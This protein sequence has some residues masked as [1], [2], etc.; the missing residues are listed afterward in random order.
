[1]FFNRYPLI[2][3]RLRGF[4]LIELIVVIAIIAVLAAIIAPNAFKAIEKS[5]CARAIEESKTIKTG[6][7]AYYSDTGLW[8]PAYRLTSTVNPFVTNPP[9]VNRWDGPYVEKWMPAH[10]W[11]GHIGWDPTIDLDG[12]GVVD[13]CVV[14]DDDRPG[15]NGGDNQGRI[16]RGSM[17]KIDGMI[18]DGNLGSGYVQG[19]GLGLAS[20]AGELVIMVVRDNAP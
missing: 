17:T 20:A 1:M 15:T 14:Y 11:A 10:P 12:S 7:F 4:T 16:P 9:G 18:D 5:K 3:K 6:A 13:G 19:D 8:P 2:A